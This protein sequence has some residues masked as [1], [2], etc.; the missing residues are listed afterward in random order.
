MK[1]LTTSAVAA[2]YLLRLASAE[3]YLLAAAPITALVPNERNL[4]VRQ[5]GICPEAT[6]TPCDDGLGCCPRGAACSYSGTRP[7]CD[8]ACGAG[9]KCPGGGCCQV[10]YKCGITND[11]CTPLPTPT[12]GSSGGSS[13]DDDDDDFDLDLDDDDDDPTIPPTVSAD[14]TGSSDD[15]D[16]DFPNL[17]SPTASSGLNDLGTLSSAGHGPTGDAGLIPDDHLPG[18]SSDDDDSS[19][20]LDVG[21][22]SGFG[23]SDDDDDDDDDGDGDS[24]SASLLGPSSLLALLA[25]SLMGVLLL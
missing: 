16:D 4:F 10:G 22:L 14:P 11:L 13:S 15:D 1:L 8:I 24:D 6:L 18:I 20:N 25:T 5:D 19:G 23:G 9:P 12:G 17:L 21:G 7:V 2:L 3:E